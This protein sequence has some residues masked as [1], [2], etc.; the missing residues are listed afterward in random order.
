MKNVGVGWT[1]VTGRE[2]VEERETPAQ[3]QARANASME[4]QREKFYG[5]W[6]WV[7]QVFGRIVIEQI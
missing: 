2:T 3:A 4:I 6:N 1:V 5:V 7:K